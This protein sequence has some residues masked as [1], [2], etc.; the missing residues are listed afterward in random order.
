MVSSGF[1]HYGIIHLGLNM[2]ALFVL[3]SALEQL[4][5]RARMAT[6]YGVGLVGGGLGALLLSP[7][8]LTAGASGAIF[9]LMG[10]IFLAQRARG[11]PFSQSPLIPVLVINLLITIGLPGISIGGHLGGLVGGGL[12]G[13][14]LFDVG[15]RPNLPKY[16]PFLGCAVIAMACVVAGVAF[17][18]GWQPS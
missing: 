4:E 18:S 13:F 8:S 17:A 3:G 10:G 9:G 16:V 14:V 15:R 12:A 11:V 7:G 2:W 1:L 5:G 6:V